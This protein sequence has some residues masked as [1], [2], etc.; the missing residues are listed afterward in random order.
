[1]MADFLY[2]AL[3]TSAVL[4]YGIGINKATVLCEKPRNVI[5]YL[6][7][8]IIT[9]V[10]SSV[11]S[12]LATVYLLV[13][14]HCTEIFPFACVLIFSVIS[15]FVEALV[16]ITAKTSAAEFA[17]SMLCVILAVNE[18]SSLVTCLIISFSCVLSFFIFIPFLYAIQKRIEIARPATDFR[19]TSLIIIS[20]ALIMITLI[21]WN[22]SWLNPGVMQ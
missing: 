7:K 9:V 1:M 13:P 17:V 4:V 3:Y 22:V 18:S 16:R 6:I 11:L 8:M 15:V 5:L 2:Y 14:V 10:T 21:V 12:Y 20:I 19:N